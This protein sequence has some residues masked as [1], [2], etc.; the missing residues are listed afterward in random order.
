MY[1]IPEKM[2]KSRKITKHGVVVPG[3]LGG[4]KRNLSR[5]TIQGVG[6]QSLTPDNRLTLW[7]TDG[8]QNP[9]RPVGELSG[10]DYCRDSRSQHLWPTP[11]RA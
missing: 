8:G 7:T 2:A 10:H 9:S 11:D 1:V 6:V 5:F 4:L 3:P